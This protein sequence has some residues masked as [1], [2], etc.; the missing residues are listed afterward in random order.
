MPTVVNAARVT[1]KDGAVW[2]EC[3]GCGVLAPLAPD[4]N[5]CTACHA[6]PVRENAV[7]A[8]LD[9]AAMHAAGPAGAAD[10]FD[11]MADAYLGL[12]QGQRGAQAVELAG[13]A[14]D[15]REAA[16]RLREGWRS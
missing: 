8:L 14:A 13:L 9:L 15:L 16:R 12:A 6:E 1:T 11:Q 10:A 5:H 3:A 2:R 4:V 7:A